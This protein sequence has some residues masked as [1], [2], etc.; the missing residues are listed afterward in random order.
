[1]VTPNKNQGLGM[2]GLEEFRSEL[3]GW[4]EENCPASMR[5]PMVEEE[6]PG[7]GLRAVYKNPDT[8]L[9]MDRCAEQGFTAPSWP[10]EYGGAGLD[11]DQ[12]HIFQEEMRSINARTPLVGMGLSMIGPALLEFGS[13]QQKSEH[14]PKII[15]GEI[16]WCQGY[17]EPGSGSDLA[18][19]RTSAEEDGDDYLINGQKIWTSGA[20]KADWMFCL[21]RTDPEASKHDGISFILFDMRSEGVTVKPILLISGKSPFC[22]TFLDNVRVPKANLVYERGK[23]WTVGK[24]LLQY[25][26]SSIGGIG[27]GQKTKTLEEYAV[28]YVGQDQQGRIA[29]SYLRSSVLD[30]RMNDAAFGLTSRRAMEESATGLAPGAL[31]S[32]FKFY[33]TEQ[34]KGK[35]E[36]LLDI[37]GVQSLGWEG[38]SFSG[39]EIN[40]TRAWLRS[41]ANS[42]EGGTSEVQLNII[43]K[44]I[45]GLPD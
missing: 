34:N 26:R 42:I 14:L 12:M 5:T 8:K 37:L 25:E 29:D 21:V 28:E 1:M 43:A 6:I 23:G 27:G 19:L 44:R 33:G 7:G 18:S 22:E 36:L 31:S 32:M 30:H 10:K 9:W 4:L 35:Y 20:D 38:S 40:T 15:S 11:K 16:W 41:K 2:S 17:S 13:D 39:E 45:L 24:R 3:R